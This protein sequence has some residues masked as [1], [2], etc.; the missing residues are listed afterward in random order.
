MVIGVPGTL[1]PVKGHEFLLEAAAALGKRREWV[2]AITGDGE[3]AFVYRL[4]SLSRELGLETRVRF[5]GTISQMPEFYRACD[6]TCVP[7]RSES[8]G[9]TVIESFAVGTP[10]VASAVGGIRETVRNEQM[11]LLVNYGDVSGLAR[12]LTRLLDDGSLRE[13]MGRA[14][15]AEAYEFFSAKTYH[16]R[17]NRIV[18]QVVSRGVVKHD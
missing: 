14:G 13:K 18:R 8:F 12:S 3:A 5:L 9:R 16:E 2:I 1:R 7:S 6:V 11:G 15:Q 4:R 17:I 10:V